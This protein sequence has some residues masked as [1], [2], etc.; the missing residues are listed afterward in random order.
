MLN[1]VLQSCVNEWVKAKT[2]KNHPFRYFTLSTVSPKNRPEARVVV[3]RHF[4]ASN[5]LFTIFTDMRTPKLKSLAHNPL[6]ELLFYDSRRNVQIRVNARC[7]YQG[8]DDEAFAQ[9]HEKAQKD[10]T[11][12]LAPGTPIKS[13][14][15]VEYTT[16]HHFCKLVFKAEKIDFLRLKRPNHQRAVFQWID[17]QWEASFLTP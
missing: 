17:Q 3:L 2:K 6:A 5:Y 8:K 12:S 16:T 7:I 10:Y 13:M 15:A 1:S 14:D 4:D 11:T 9:Q